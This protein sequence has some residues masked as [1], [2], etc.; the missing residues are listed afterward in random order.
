MLPEVQTFTEAGLKD[1]V[2]D[3]WLGIMAPAKTPPAITDKLSAESIKVLSDEGLRR[4]LTE[5]GVEPVGSSAAAFG[6]QVR[7][8]VA[9]WGRVVRDAQIKLAP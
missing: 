2:V 3:T 9:R 6:E 7:Q 5:L 1:F 4:R 8:D